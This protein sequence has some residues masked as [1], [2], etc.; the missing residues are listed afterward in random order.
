[1]AFFHKQRQNTTVEKPL[2]TLG[3]K[4]NN[5]DD[6]KVGSHPTERARPLCTCAERE[7]KRENG[8]GASSL[9]IHD[10]ELFEKRMFVCLKCAFF[11][12]AS[13]GRPKWKKPFV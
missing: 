9:H 13:N 5:V 8:C 6:G 1:M 11:A 3:K 4:S 12:Y 10:S 2:E 7:R